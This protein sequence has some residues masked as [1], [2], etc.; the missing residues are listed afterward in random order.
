MDVLTRKWFGRGKF[1]I[2]A[3][4]VDTADLNKTSHEHD[5]GDA[6]QQHGPP[7]SLEASS[8]AIDQDRFKNTF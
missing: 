7:M 8:K 6:H 2:T 3:W 5:E 4:C 1:R